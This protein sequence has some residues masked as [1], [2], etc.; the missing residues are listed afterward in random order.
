MMLSM[1]VHPNDSKHRPQAE[2]GTVEPLSAESPDARPVTG[3]DGFIYRPFSATAPFNIEDE[4]KRVPEGATVKGVIINAVTDQLVVAESD[5]RRLF[6]N[7]PMTEYIHR[8]VEVAKTCWP[9]VPIREGLR[10]LGHGHYSAFTSTA[11]GRVV[12]GVLGRRMENVFRASPKGYRYTTDCSDCSII[13]V[14]GNVGVVEIAGLPF[15]DSLQVGVYEG[16]VRATGYDP[17]VEVG[18]HPA[19]A[20]RLRVT[21]TRAEEG[22]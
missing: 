21:W 22:K 18:H 2:A 10:R 19:G 17:M 8:C 9:D 3:E 13:S 14:E 7:Y 1:M 6:N 11:I 5:S 15:A 20:I 16:G 4:L 12:F